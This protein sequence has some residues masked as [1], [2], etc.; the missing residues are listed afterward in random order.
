MHTALFCLFLFFF[1]LGNDILWV[2]Y[3][4]ATAEK[5]PL[6]SAMWAFIIYLPVGVITPTLARHPWYVF[7]LAAGAF[8]GTFLTVRYSRNKKKRLDNAG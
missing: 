2:N 1:A 4:I 3:T 6:H 7:P 8:V 5:R